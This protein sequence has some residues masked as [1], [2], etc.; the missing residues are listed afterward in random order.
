EDIRISD[1]ILKQ[2]SDAY[3]RIRNTSR[4][5]LGNLFDFNPDTDTVPYSE[6]QELDRYALHRL[7]KLVEKNLRAYEN[8]EFHTIYH[9]LYNFCIVD[10]SSFYLDILKDR[11]YTS[12]TPSRARRSAQT[13]LHILVDALARL[14]APILPFTSEEI[15]KYMPERE[16]KTESIHLGL[17]PEVN[18]TQ[19]DDELAG[20]WSKLLEVRGE[21]TKALEEARAAKRIGHSLD[22]AVQIKATPEMMA[23]LETFNDELATLFI[24]S[25]AALA[26]GGLEGDIYESEEVADLKIAVGPAGGDKC[27]RCWI[28]DPQVG[29]NQAHP[30][31]CPK[32]LDALAAVE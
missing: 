4:F 19:V 15:W 20:R 3:R 22:A 24:V 8:Y 28:S 31:I 27:A 26:D 9:S 6:M 25:Q 29:E 32:C 12:P 7:Q 14:M 23:S 18:A 13:V 2:L 17:L 30:T 11:L 10:M 1:S 16:G 5:M 21:V